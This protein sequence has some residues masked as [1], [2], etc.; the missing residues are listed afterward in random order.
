[1][2][3]KGTVDVGVGGRDV[4]RLKETYDHSFISRRE[5]T[6]M[7]KEGEKVVTEG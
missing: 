6:Q 1:M 5:L 7:V 3:Q 2:L 4:D